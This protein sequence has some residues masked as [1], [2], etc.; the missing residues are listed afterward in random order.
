M[1]RKILW[2]K[3]RRFVDSGFVKKH[4]MNSSIDSSFKSTFQEHGQSKIKSIKYWENSKNG[5]IMEKS[6]VPEMIYISSYEINGRI[7]EPENKRTFFDTAEICHYVYFTLIFHHLRFAVSIQLI[8]SCCSI[9]IFC[10]I[11]LFFDKNQWF[12]W[13]E[14]KLPKLDSVKLKSDKIENC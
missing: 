14:L 11:S 1:K 13:I 7:F 9:Q 6:Q 3:I 4:V 12:W 5:S 8:C 2:E 10:L